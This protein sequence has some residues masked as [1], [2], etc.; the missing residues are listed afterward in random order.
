MVYQ[1]RIIFV[2]QMTHNNQAMA[3]NQQTA[4][5]FLSNQHISTAIYFSRIYVNGGL[6][7]PVG[8]REL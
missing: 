6:F 3:S 8:G 2:L 7:L 4:L 5:A 1:S